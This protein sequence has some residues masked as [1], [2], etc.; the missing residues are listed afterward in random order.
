M[1]NM[2]TA[3]KILAKSREVIAER[4]RGLLWVIVEYVFGPFITK[5]DHSKSCSCLFF[6]HASYCF[7][8]LNDF[9]INPQ[10]NRR[11]LWYSGLQYWYRIKISCHFRF[12]WTTEA[13]CD[14]IRK[15]TRL[16]SKNTENFPDC[17]TQ[18]I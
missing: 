14:W 11:S 12:W 4:N 10:S 6:K 1:V 16:L 9:A 5:H 3:K 8:W 15:W 18:C 7:I 13:L 2:P 17:Y